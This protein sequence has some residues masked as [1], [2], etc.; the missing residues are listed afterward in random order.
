[1]L[2][3][4]VTVCLLPHN[5]DLPALQISD[6]YA[7]VFIYTSGAEKFFLFS[8]SDAMKKLIAVDV[9][10]PIRLPLAL[11]PTEAS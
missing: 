1:M 4:R 2:V 8:V 10:V 6:A 3:L 11:S 7:N 9:K 5:M